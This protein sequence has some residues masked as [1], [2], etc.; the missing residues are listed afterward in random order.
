M[1]AG[2]HDLHLSADDVEAVFGCFVGCLGDYTMDSRGDI[3]AVVREAA[4]EGLR[5]LLMVVTVYDSSL[6]TPDMYVCVCVC[7]L[8]S[9]PSPD[10]W[11]VQ[12]DCGSI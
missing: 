1:A 11:C 6:L 7:G 5:K 2:S 4:M 3:G 12:G 9:M 10:V 8:L